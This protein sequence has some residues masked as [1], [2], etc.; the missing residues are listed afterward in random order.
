MNRFI[1]EITEAKRKV[2]S[3]IE[4]ITISVPKAN[5]SQVVMVCD[6][7]TSED[8]FHEWPHVDEIKWNNAR[9]FTDLNNASAAFTGKL[10]HESGEWSDRA[11]HEINKSLHIVDVICEVYIRLRNDIQTCRV[12]AVEFDTGTD[13][14]LAIFFENDPNILSIINR[15]NVIKPVTPL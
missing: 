12:F 10:Q 3:P 13:L 4:I 2:V 7:F 15:L 6:T 11:V 5:N 1:G 14:G 8:E 9:Y